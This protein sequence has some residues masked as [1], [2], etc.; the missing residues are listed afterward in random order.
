[1]SH[2][3]CEP[4][5]SQTGIEPDED[6]ATDLSGTGAAPFQLDLV[7]ALHSLRAPANAA[8]M[9]DRPPDHLMRVARVQ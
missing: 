9:A 7:R 4:E 8:V 3:R 5:E 1:M 2:D 6:P